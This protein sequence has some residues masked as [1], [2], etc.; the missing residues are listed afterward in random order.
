MNA[1]Y[2]TLFARNKNV[3]A[4]IKQ[5]TE[6]W[7]GSERTNCTRMDGIV[8]VTLYYWP[9]FV[10]KHFKEYVENKIEENRAYVDNF[11]ATF[12]DFGV[13]PGTKNKFQK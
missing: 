7:E 12:H 4:K 8:T 13:E 2:D 6:G 10:M 11:L 9:N 5:S 3:E 1:I